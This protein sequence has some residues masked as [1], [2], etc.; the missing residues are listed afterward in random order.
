MRMPQRTIHLNKM[1]PY[2]NVAYMGY[3][4]GHWEGDTLVV[5]RRP[6][7]PMRPGSTGPGISIAMRLHVTERYTPVGKDAI[8]L[9]SHH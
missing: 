4:V 9:R 2:P 5:E 1:E 6:I 7:S 3:S 8:Q